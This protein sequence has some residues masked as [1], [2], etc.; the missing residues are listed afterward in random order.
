LGYSSTSSEDEDGADASEKSAPA[1]ACVE[2]TRPPTPPTSSPKVDDEDEADSTEESAPAPVEAA[3]RLSR[4]QQ[5]EAA[6]AARL[7][8]IAGTGAKET[9]SA[10]EVGVSATSDSFSVATKSQKY[11]DAWENSKDVLIDGFSIHVLGKQLF[12]NAD[13]KLVHGRKYGFVGPNGQGKTTLLTLIASGDLRVPKAVDVLLVAQEAVADD[14]TAV[15]AVLAADVKRAQLMS[16]EDELLAREDD[17]TPEDLERLTEIS[18]QL[19][20]YT[21]SEAAARKILAGLGFTPGMQ[22]RATKTFSGGWR[23]RIS[24][25]KALFMRPTLLLLDEP[26]NHLDLNAVIWLDDYL[27]TWKSTILVVSHDQ[28]FL[29][30]VCDSIIHLENKKLNYF[31]LV[32]H[33]QKVHKIQPQ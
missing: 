26:T 18:S 22:D 21:G 15:N 33:C 27:Q 23:M 7:A 13:L 11:D 4:K 30:S 28:G 10:E 25:A 17:L 24:L 32:D 1:P 31:S 29:S 12:V 20:E 5:R 9:A 16:E 2:S 19:S 8:E 6:R 3:P 14:T